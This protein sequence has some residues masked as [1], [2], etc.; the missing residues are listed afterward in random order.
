D[1]ECEP[2]AVHGGADAEEQLPVVRVGDRKP[3]AA[4]RVDLNGAGQH[5]KRPWL[6]VVVR[7]GTGAGLRD[8]LGVLPQVHRARGIVRHNASVPPTSPSPPGSKVTGP[9]ASGPAR[10]LS[11]IDGRRP[12]SGRVRPPR[13]AR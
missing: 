2:Y 12:G 8:L 9:A 7:W 3:A 6:R 11:A 5:A 4:V 13:E 10:P 1:G